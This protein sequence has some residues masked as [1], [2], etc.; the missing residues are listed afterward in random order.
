MLC[1]SQA[2]YL[3]KILKR[4]N[5]SECKCA[6]TPIGTHFKLSSIQDESEFID[7]EKTPYSSAVGSMMYA[8]I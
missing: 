2:G 4:F 1:L 6:L 5:M 8:M 7:T 3:N